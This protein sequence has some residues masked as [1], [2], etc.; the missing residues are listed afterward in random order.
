MP[1]GKT[2]Y[3]APS[4]ND[5][6]PG[7]QAK[8]W[9]TVQH[10]ASTLQP[11]DTALVENGTYKG[12]CVTLQTSGLPGKPI[13]LK[14]YPGHSPRLETDNNNG[15]YAILIQASYIEVSGFDVAFTYNTGDPKGWNGNGIGVR[16]DGMPDKVAHHIRIINNKVH[17]F[18]GGGIETIWADYVTLEGNA[19][20]GNAFWGIYQNSGISLYQNANSDQVSGTHNVIR[21][22]VSYRNE[23]KVPNTATPPSITDG[24]CII[25]D[26]SRNTQNWTNQPNQPHQ[27]VRYT[28][29]T[30]VENNVCFDNGGRGVHVYSSDNVLARN[31]TLYQDQQTSNINDG[32]LTAIDASNVRFAN[33]VVY[34]ANGRRANGTYN[35][36]NIVFERNLYFNTTDIPNKAAND[37]IGLDPKFV[38][39]STDPALANFRLQSSSPAI[40]AAL[41]SQ[42]PGIDLEGHARPQGA[43]PD[44]GAYELLK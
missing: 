31:N 19:V 37:L 34:T 38:Q 41:A 32:E 11:G 2:F 44:L 33:N 26:D 10:A 3:V 7:S 8:P 36:T 14:A 12:G 23:N 43:A 20:Y 5:A 35:A 39:G 9:K 22:N 29:L 27:N 4:G 16:G 13:T 18:P 15:C 25:I 30:L 21:G 24:N 1:T 42:M 28:G 6:D 17:D 40:D